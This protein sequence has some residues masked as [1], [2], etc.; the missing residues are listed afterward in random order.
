MGTQFGVP[1]DGTCQDT[2]TFPGM[3]ADLALQPVGG[4]TPSGSTPTG[5]VTADNPT[6]ICCQ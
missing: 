6:T 1:A 4:C 2:S 3:A 5:A